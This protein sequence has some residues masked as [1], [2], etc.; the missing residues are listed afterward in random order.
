[1]GKLQGKVAI[2]TGSSNQKGIGFNVAKRFCSEG[3][4]VVLVDIKDA[5][6]VDAQRVLEA[7]F[8][9]GRARYLRADITQEYEYNAL[10]T[11]AMRIYKRVDVS[12]LRHNF[13][14]VCRLHCFTMTRYCATMRVGSLHVPVP[15]HAPL[16]RDSVSRDCHRATE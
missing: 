1:M 8:G 11:E 16:M 3:A 10:F 4:S 2:I 6:G 14:T 15:L 9:T 7:Q 13:G 5:E 12:A